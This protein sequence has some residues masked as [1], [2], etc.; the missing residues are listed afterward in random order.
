MTTKP[1][2]DAAQWWTTSS[3]GFQNPLI[4]YPAF[5][6]WQFGSFFT[7]V[8]NT[9]IGKN[10]NHSMVLIAFLFSTKKTSIFFLLLDEMSHQTYD[11]PLQCSEW[12]KP[13]A[14]DWKILS[15]WPNTEAECWVFLELLSICFNS[16]LFED[17]ILTLLI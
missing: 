1:V 10:L 15:L 8:W 14:E 16:I 9:T 13:K 7:K 4:I 17:L 2:E 5:V 6:T 12:P 3:N 11:G